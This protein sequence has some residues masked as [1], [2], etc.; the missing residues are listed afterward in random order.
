MKMKK[1]K[2]MSQSEVEQYIDCIF[3]IHNFMW[4]V[5]EEN[6]ISLTKRDIFDPDDAFLFEPTDYIITVSKLW[7]D[8]VIYK[9]STIDNPDLTFEEICRACN[10]KTSLF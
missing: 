1:I 9:A 6:E 3:H 10:L 4:D 2:D 7:S 5:A 8:E